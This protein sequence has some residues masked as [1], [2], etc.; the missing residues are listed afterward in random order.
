MINESTGIIQLEPRNEQVGRL[1]KHFI[2]KNGWHINRR[3]NNFRIND[4]ETVTLFLNGGYE[5][6][7]S[8]SRLSEVMKQGKVSAYKGKIQAYANIS[9]GK[10]KNRKYNLHRFLM[11]E[12]LAMYDGFH[13]DTGL[14]IVVHHIDGD[15]LNNTDENLQV[16]TQNEN[17]RIGAANSKYFD[18]IDGKVVDVFPYQDDTGKE[19]REAYRKE[20]EAE[21]KR[22]AELRS[23]WLKS[24][25]RK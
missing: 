1:L 4:G 20:V 15:T 25:G 9:V 19:A 7:I 14:I 3:F 24:K 6:K 8:R 18:V 5:T 11:R 2:R 12:E 23:N 13:E 17:L 22:L 10:G 21:L 16:L